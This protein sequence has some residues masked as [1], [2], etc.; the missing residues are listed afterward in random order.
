MKNSEG[1]NTFQFVVN[2]DFIKHHGNG[3]VDESIKNGLPLYMGG[4]TYCTNGYSI[5][6]KI[7]NASGGYIIYGSCK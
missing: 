6:E 1:R 7:K 4:K 2:S 3:D 5:D